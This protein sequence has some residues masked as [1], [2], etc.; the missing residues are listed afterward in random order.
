[1]IDINPKNNTECTKL[2]KQLCPT[3]KPNIEVI[4]SKDGFLSDKPIKFGTIIPEFDVII[5]NPPYQSGVVKGKTSIK[6]MKARKRSGLDLKTHRN[7]WIPFVT[8]ILTTNI[9]KP[10]GYLLF[11]TPITWFR[12]EST[13]IH[14]LILQHQIHHLRIIFVTDFQKFFDGKGSISVAH[15]LLQ[16]KQATTST[17]IIDRYNHSSMIKLDQNSIIISGHNEIYQKIRAKCDDF[18]NSNDYKI[19]SIKECKS[20]SNKQ[21]Y[22]IDMYDRIKF[23]KTSAIHPE[24]NTP[25]IVLYGNHWP[26]IYYDKEGK[27]G[28]I[29]QH[30]NYFVGKNLQKLVDFFKTKLSALL[31]KNIKYEQEFIAPRFLPDIR[32]LPI[33]IIND[34]TLASY[35]GFSSKERNL[36]NLTEFPKREFKFTEMTCSEIYTP[37]RKTMK[38]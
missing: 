18:Q 5:G 9:L 28:L 8:K 6:T 11:I 29:G 20:G 38:Q 30:Q 12:P 33:N 3:A 23:V 32:N 37:K 27:Y 34:E 4:D 26:R 2:L 7:L 22:R 24:Q 1:M 10:D 15:Y 36:I 17:K 16:K 25:K 31:L 14:D 13:G 21:I 19:N 35:F